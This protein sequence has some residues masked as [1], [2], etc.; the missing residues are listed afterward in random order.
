MIDSLS[1]AEKKFEEFLPILKEKYPTGR[2]NKA[3]IIK[4][5]NAY[6]DVFFNE[7]ILVLLYDNRTM[8]LAFIS[9]NCEAFSGY[10]SKKVLAWGSLLLFKILHYSHYSFLYHI[11]R[12]DS[13]FSKIQTREQR[14]N[15]ILYCSG[16]KFNDANG[17]TRQAFLKC[18]TILVDEKNQNDFMVIF[19]EE[20]THLTKGNH[21][22]L[23]N[24]SGGETKALVNQKGKKDFGDLVTKSEKKVL[25]LLAEKKTTGEI[26]KLL[27]LSELTVQTHRKNM[28]KRVGAVDSTALVHLC[29]MANVI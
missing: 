28:I 4:Y 15:N 26:A 7:N 1:L 13:H 19:M 20:V 25:E 2:K 23:R 8:S 22:W 10:T 6:Q 24:E 12:W 14:L 9:D 16:V 21:F 5:I 3:N 29:K 18:K 17:K 11:F 27:N